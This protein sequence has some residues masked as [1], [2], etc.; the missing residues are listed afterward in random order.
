[1]YY[2]RMISITDTLIYTPLALGFCDYEVENNSHGLYNWTETEV[3]STAFQICE[4]GEEVHGGRAER[5]CGSPRV[6]LHYDGESCITRVTHLFTTL[7]NV[8]YQ[9][10]CQISAV[11]KTLSL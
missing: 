5:M 9:L 6:W 10:V 11:I 2:T 4:F 3:N 1:M 7:S 8:S